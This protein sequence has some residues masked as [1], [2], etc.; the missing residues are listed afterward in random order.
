MAEVDYRWNSQNITIQGKG[1]WTYIKWCG[2]GWSTSQF[3]VCVVAYD[4]V[5]TKLSPWPNS[6]C[7]A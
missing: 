6:V 3:G 2:Q 4:L 5:A 1:H 7:V